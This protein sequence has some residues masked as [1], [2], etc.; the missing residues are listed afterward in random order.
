MHGMTLPQIV[1]ITFLQ[2]VADELLISLRSS[3]PEF[4]LNVSTT[5][6]PYNAQEFEGPAFETSQALLMFCASCL[7]VC[8]AVAGLGDNVKCKM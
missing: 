5:S 7:S 2:V 1:Y 4:L 3:E 8:V 6:M